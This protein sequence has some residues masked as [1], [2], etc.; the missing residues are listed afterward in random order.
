[1]SC[2]LAALA[3]AGV[4]GPAATAQ[5][6]PRV[7]ATQDELDAAKA[8]AASQ[9]WAKSAMDS[10]LNAAAQWPSAYQ[11]KYGLSAPEAPDAGGQWSQWYVCPKHGV[12]LRYT[13]PSTH[14]CPIDNQRLTGWPYDDVIISR[15]HNDLAAAARN[16]ALAWRWTGETSYGEQAA[17]ILKSYAR[18]YAGFALHDKDGKNTRSGARAHSQTLDESVW[19][20][21]LA[22]AYDLIRESPFLTLDERALIESELFRQAVATIQRNDAK[23]SNW[24]SWHNAAIGAAGFAIDDSAMVRD[25]ID[26]PSGFR[27]QMKKSITSE[28]FWY[29]GAWGYHFY[30]LD[31]LVQLAEAA[32]R[33]GIDLYAEEPALRR[34]FESPL[35]LTFPNGRLPAFNDSREVDLYSYDRLYEAA[36]KRYGDPLLATVLGRNSRTLNALLWG[37][38]DLPK[39]EPPALQ[40]AVFPES[41]YAVLRAPAGDHTVI[42]KFG[43]HGGWHGHYDKPGFVSYANGATMAI[44]PGTQSYAAPTH[45]TWDKVTVAHNTVVV[46]EGV[47]KEST[48]ALLWA[49]LDAPEYRAVRVSAGTDAVPGVT[50]ERTLLLTTEYA[51]DLFDAVSTDGKSRKFDWIYHNEGRLTAEPA[52]EG[53]PVLPK[54]NGYQHLTNLAGGRV[55]GPW[56]AAFDPTPL[57]DAPFGS[58][59]NSNAS[60]AGTFLRTT[61]TAHSGRF[62][63]LAKYQFKAAGYILY[64]APAPQNLPEAVPSG[65][66]IMVH[67]D[68]S[69]HRL[70]LRLY[71]ATDERFAI[72]AGPI[73]W[74]GWKEVTVSDPGKWSHYLG[75]NDGIVDL[76][77][78]QISVQVDYVSGGPAEGVIAIDDITVHYAGAPAVNA[79]DF[80]VPQRNLRVWMAGVEGTTL[81]TGDGLGPDL[82]VPV[83]FVMAR[84]QGTA[85]EFAAL[86]EPYTNEPNVVRFEQEP[87]EWFTVETPAFLDRFRLTATGVR[88]FS[89]TRK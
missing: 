37:V 52:P 82:T 86:L 16:L 10:V 42:A 61:S 56:K 49:E 9:P 41:G 26:G 85:A 72:L 84:R 14:V 55:D 44:D 15:R 59:Y 3:L 58:V 89:R 64:T 87:G 69:G 27:F 74:T 80:E 36:Y 81:V 62:A 48:G 38:A 24:Q 45:N 21:P 39:T 5:P 22:W 31:P 47:Q 73:D 57:R 88:D 35:K 7:F 18:R 67:G 46:D 20:L 11:T 60:V 28:G 30:A 77:I 8:L 12:S 1:M 76:P 63:G 83:P 68:G 43:P 78:K 19:L 33:N 34:M 70:T 54:T 29:E 13:P 71:D 17:W 32:A 51:I 6:G 50:L 75:N 66:S 4:L 23:E 65:L 53:A 25:A 79:V 40:S 2:Y